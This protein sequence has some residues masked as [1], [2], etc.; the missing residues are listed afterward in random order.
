[1]TTIRL[2]SSG[3]PWQ[4]D[5]GG[6][7]ADSDDLLDRALGAM[8]EAKLAGHGDGFDDDFEGSDEP[9]E[10]SDCETSSDEGM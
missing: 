10:G 8:L 1:M 7:D 5:D 9:L 6:G 4:L 3:D 2:Y